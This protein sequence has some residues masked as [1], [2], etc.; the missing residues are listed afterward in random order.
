MSIANDTP[1]QTVTRQH[2]QGGT[3][4]TMV[5]AAITL[6]IGVL[7][8]NQI[9]GALPTTSSGVNRSGI[10]DVISSAFQL[11]PVV[12]IVL[13]AALVLAQVSGFGRS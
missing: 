7:V 5:T 1:A 6:I 13:V 11:A 4:N 8:F 10:V 2:D 12:L 9:L 3:F